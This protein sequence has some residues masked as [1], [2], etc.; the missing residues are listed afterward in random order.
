MKQKKVSLS[1]WNCVSGQSGPSSS[2]HR[3][4]IQDNRVNPTKQSVIFYIHFL[5]YNYYRMLDT[6]LFISKLVFLPEIKIRRV[7]KSDALNRIHSK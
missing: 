6:N 4:Y 5:F 2:L 7:R 3:I 1:L